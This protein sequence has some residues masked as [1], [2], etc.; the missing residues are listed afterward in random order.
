M[1]CEESA[2]LH[3]FEEMD[4][5]EFAQFHVELMEHVPGLSQAGAAARAALL[6]IHGEPGAAP[7][8]PAAV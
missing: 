3:L 1:S 5:G 2:D 6:Q 7:G 4:E 8:S